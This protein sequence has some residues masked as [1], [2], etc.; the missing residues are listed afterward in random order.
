M[1][2]D[3]LI[4]LRKKN[5]PESEGSEKSP[6]KL[7]VIPLLIYWSFT[8][9]LA[10][11]YAGEKMPWL[12]VHI[13]LP[14]LLAAGWGV[15]FLIDRLNLKK[16]VSQKFLISVSLVILFI[17]SFSGMLG[18]LFGTTPPFQGNTLDQLK[19]TSTFLLSFLVAVLSSGFGLWLMKKWEVR[20]ML[21]IIMLVIFVILGGL[22]ARNA[23]M[24]SFV[25]YDTAKEY[26]VYAHAA[27]GP[28]DILEQVEEISQRTTGGLDIQVAYDND[29]LYPYWWYFRNYPNHRWYTDTPTR[30]LSEYPIIISG[31]STISKIDP[32]VKDNYVMFEYMRLW[33]P[34]QDY[35]NLTWDRIKNAV[36]DPAIRAGNL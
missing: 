3:I 7:P 23:Y 1:C 31:T 6:V 15:G 13:A 2:L 10:Y 5:V 22:T 28:K 35:F 33:W 4:L 34:N 9:L 11:S 32:I 20:H 12:T 8:S 27:R 14:M 36:N 30:D 19:A 16:M 18:S 24:A 26:L 25:N 17:F 29:S 21:S